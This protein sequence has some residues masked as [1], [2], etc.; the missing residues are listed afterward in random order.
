MEKLFNANIV[1]IAVDSSLKDGIYI[2]HIK[3][4]KHIVKT[5][6]TIHNMKSGMKIHSKNLFE[7]LIFQNSLIIAI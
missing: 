4:F 1:N 7:V 6:C 5:F 3:N 2:Q